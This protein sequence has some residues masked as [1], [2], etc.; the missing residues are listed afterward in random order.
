MTP[1]KYI[2]QDYGLQDQIIFYAATDE[3]IKQY[4]QYS[5]YM[6][7]E[8]PIHATN[9]LNQV[10]REKLGN[11]LRILRGGIIG[12]NTVL[13]QSG[14]CFIGPKAKCKDQVVIKD[15]AVILST[16]YI[17]GHVYIMDN[18]R[19][20]N[21]IISAWKSSKINIM[22]YTNLENISLSCFTPTTL[23]NTNICCN[24]EFNSKIRLH[25]IIN[26]AMP[27][28]DININDDNYF[29]Y[30]KIFT[31]H[32]KPYGAWVDD[33]KH[34]YCILSVNDGLNNGITI[35]LDDLIK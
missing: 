22:G 8:F 2:R 23:Y 4:N 24:V 6:Y 34:N 13:D 25:L 18:S 14:H 35:L 27:I 33:S 9:M 26:D 17:D 3:M 31:D 12:L 7:D 19:I 10:E 21:S 16:S 11:P 28:F 32:K 5:D 20:I 1:L 29:E 15:D 30:L